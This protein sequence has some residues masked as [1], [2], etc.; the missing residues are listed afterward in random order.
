MDTSLPSN[1]FNN[2][3]NLTDIYVCWS[4]GEIG[5]APWGATNATIHY[6]TPIRFYIG[7]TEYRGLVDMTFDEWV[8]SEYNTGGFY[9]NDNGYI[10]N[11][12]G[13]FV[14]RILSN[15]LLNKIKSPLKITVEYKFYLEA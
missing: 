6:N 11:T 9:V 12:E 3:P 2:C 14:K 8:N 15:G 13:L 10:Q 4:E 7:D 1:I 5:N